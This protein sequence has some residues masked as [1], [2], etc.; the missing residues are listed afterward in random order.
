MAKHLMQVAKFFAN[1]FWDKSEHIALAY[2]PAMNIYV[3]RE[4]LRNFIEVQVHAVFLVIGN[5]R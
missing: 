5:N 4:I 3:G 2:F 1:M